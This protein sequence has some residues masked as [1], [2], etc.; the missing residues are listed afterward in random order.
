MAFASEVLVP[1]AFVVFPGY[2]YLGVP[3]FLEGDV[4]ACCLV[5]YPAADYP[6]LA[7]V[8]CYRFVVAVFVLVSALSVVAA[9]GYGV[10][11]PLSP[12]FAS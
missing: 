2:H 7:V 8:V 11:Y 6:R 12:M 5:D 10:F 1:A 4:E 3:D 9:V